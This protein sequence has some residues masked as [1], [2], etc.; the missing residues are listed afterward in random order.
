MSCSD[1]GLLSVAGDSCRYQYQKKLCVRR[2]M[3]IRRMVHLCK[4][5]CSGRTLTIL[6]LGHCP[7]GPGSVGGP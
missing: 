6:E 4:Y 7:E 5:P 3:P 2:V 1:R